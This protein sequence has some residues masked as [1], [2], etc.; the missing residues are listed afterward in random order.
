MNFGFIFLF[1]GIQ[2]FVDYLMLNP[3]L[4]KDSRDTI[5]LIAGSGDKEVQ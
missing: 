4:L 3:Y 1:N 2:T 5:Y